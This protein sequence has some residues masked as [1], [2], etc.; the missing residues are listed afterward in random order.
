MGIRSFISGEKRNK[1]LKLKGTGEQRQFWGTG[2]IE[3]QDFDFWEEGK[4]P[5]FFFRRTREQVPP[6]TPH[7]PLWASVFLQLAIQKWW[8]WCCLIFIWSYGRLLLGFFNP[9]PAVT[10]TPTFA[11]SV[12]PDQMASEEAI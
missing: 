11:N 3:N 12:D 10:T 4:M 5:I 7:P 2:N 6:P 1:S 8:L 9:Y